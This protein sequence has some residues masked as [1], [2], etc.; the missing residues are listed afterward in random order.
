M[1]AQSHAFDP[2]AYKETTKAQWQEAAGAWHRWTPTISEWLAPVTEAM[3]SMGNISKGARLLEVAAGAGDPSVQFAERVG[4]SG[5]VLATD[6]SSNL[7]EYAAEEA[8]KRG[9][10]NYETRV[11]DGENLDLP[12]AQ[13]DVA[14]SRV[15]LIYFPDQVKALTGLGS[16]LKPGGRTVN[17]VYST[18]ENNGFFSVPIGV[19][20]RRAQLPPPLPGQP[21]PFSLGTPGVLESLYAR[22]GFDQIETR[23]VAAPLR[24]ASA[25]ECLK[26][27]KESFGALHQ[28]LANMPA[29][30]Q[31][32]VWQE[33]EDELRQFEGSDGFVAP[34]ELIVGVG[35]NPG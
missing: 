1:T 7:L 3:I 17:A 28:M 21:G 13:F 23:V 27:E 16:V 6:I 25:A 19:I 30:E 20:R 14:T 34:C 26:F 8:R 35:V 31:E 18:A 33:I 10:T 22:A 24:M 11:M 15:G 29:E 2:V 9:L 5:S 4:P 12:E 32:S